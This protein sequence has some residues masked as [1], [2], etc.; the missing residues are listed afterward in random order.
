MFASKT[1]PN[2]LRWSVTVSF[3]WKYIKYSLSLKRFKSLNLNARM[4]SVTMA[5]N[6][7]GDVKTLKTFWTYAIIKKDIMQNVLNYA[8]LYIMIVSVPSPDKRG[9]RR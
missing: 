3:D 8:T 1:I 9:G 7:F 4:C 6:Y 5:H 2:H